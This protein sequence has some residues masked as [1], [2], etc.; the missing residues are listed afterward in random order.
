MIEKDDEIERVKREIQ[1]MI[2][3]IGEI[4]RIRFF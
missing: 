2:E 4:K 1:A 3:E